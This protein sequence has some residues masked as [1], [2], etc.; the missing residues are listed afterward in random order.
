MVRSSVVVVGA[1]VA[2]ACAG[3]D[4]AAEPVADTAQ[5]AIYGDDDRVEVF[6]LDAVDPARAVALD[7]VAAMVPAAQLRIEQAAVSVDGPSFGDAHALCEGVRFAEQPVIAACSA[8]L[9]DDDLVLTAGHCARLCSVSRIVFGLHYD[10]PAALRAIMPEDVFDCVDVVADQIAAD[11]VDVAWLR[12]DRPVGP[13]R[14]PAQLRLDSPR[15]D[16]PLTL[17][18]F[19]MGIP[20]KADAGGGVTRV[21][22]DVFFTTHDAFEGSSGGPLLDAAG[23]VIGVLGGGAADL[24]TTAEGCAVPLRLPP[25]PG[26]ER[27]TVVTRALEELCAAEPH[28][29]LCCTGSNH[30]CERTSD[31]ARGCAVIGT[32]A[33]SSWPVILALTILACFFAR[34]G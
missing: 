26:D 2:C 31:E 3:V 29:P 7:A 27:S 22:G 5:P 9:V 14:R 1:I 25:A 15:V 10:A 13:E 18:G 19:P 17:L 4:D 11:G 28:E 21:D 6:A 32:S 24:V 20:M 12:L 8:V 30:A 23:E 33:G 34:R 16:E